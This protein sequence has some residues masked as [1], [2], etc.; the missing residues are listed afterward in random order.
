M[1]LCR[2]RQ[3]SALSA[4]AMSQVASILAEH[5]DMTGTRVG[6]DRA[7]FPALFVDIV[8]YCHLCRQDPQMAQSKTKRIQVSMSPD[9]RDMS[10]D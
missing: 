8:Q 3:Y 5:P 10:F 2:F 1:R 4:P 9:D 6:M 7:K